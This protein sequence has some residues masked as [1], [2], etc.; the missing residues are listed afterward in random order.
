MFFFA[1]PAGLTVLSQAA[2]IVQAYGGVAAFAVGATT[3]VTGAV[4]AARIGGWP[5]DHFAAARVGV[6]AHAC[7]PARAML[8]MLNPTPGSAGKR[9]AEALW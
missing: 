5:V 3:F 6:G 4:D 9:T 7:S 2:A 1:A 8:L